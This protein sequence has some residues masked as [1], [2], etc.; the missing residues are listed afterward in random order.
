MRFQ[1]VARVVLL[2][3]A[4]CSADHAP[5]VRASNSG[6]GRGIAGVA[7]QAG[8]GATPAGFHNSN[9]G[10]AATGCA[11]ASADSD[12]DHDGYTKAQG[13]CNDCR[14]DIH[15]GA[16]EVPG[17]NIDEDCNGKDTV[18]G[19]PAV[20]PTMP[21]AS[22]D[23]GLALD[24]QDALDGAHAIGLC[25]GVLK[26]SYTDAVG[27]AGLRS[28]LQVGLLE[29]FGVVKP[30]E[31]KRLLL[32]SSGV[33]RTPE[34]TD[35]TKQCDDFSMT[36]GTFP[37][38]DAPTPS[39][40][41]EGYPKAP[42]A[43]CGYPSTPPKAMIYDPAALSLS[44]QAPADAH[45]FSVDFSFYTSEYPAGLCGEV[46]DSFVIL[47]DPPPPG[48]DHGNIAFDA[49][50]NSISVNTSLLR[51]C[52]Q[53]PEASAPN[54]QAYTCPLGGNDLSGTGYDG[55]SCG[56]DDLPGGATGWLNTTVAVTA[57]SEFSLR[58]LIMD[59]G[60]GNYDSSVVIDHFRWLR[61][62]AT[63]PPVRE[64]PI[65]QPVPPQ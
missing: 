3:L 65:T 6:A 24:S 42:P 1:F 16:A 55:Q 36:T 41:P 51:V 62:E 37:M 22:C 40:A 54:A 39:T 5:G 57:G 58:F 14:A 7:G 4:S 20:K 33:A 21:P 31:G 15:P 53:P 43:V 27:Q 63:D 18:E 35:Y 49:D 9:G 2:G 17:N 19:T 29:N 59:A 25:D 23:D 12:Y 47:M 50:G 60:D 52:A 56:W 32:L 11:A 44:L 34:E 30:R 13:D 10:S 26:A 46:N 64:V 38:P 45:G 48:A 8:A 61:D 28:K